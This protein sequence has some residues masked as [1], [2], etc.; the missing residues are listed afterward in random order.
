MC[1]HG[2]GCWRFVEVALLFGQHGS[3][4]TTIDVHPRV[5][6]V[7]H[8][9]VLYIMWLLAPAARQEIRTDRRMVLKLS[10]N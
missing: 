2:L 4:G 1:M 7:F 6:C 5:N 3:T 9:L 8:L 10:K